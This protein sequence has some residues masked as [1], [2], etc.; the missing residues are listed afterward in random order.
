MVFVIAITFI[1]CDS[2]N[3]FDCI[4]AEGSTVRE[5]KILPDFQRILVNRGV[6]LI[7]KQG[8]TQQVIIEA[9]ENLIND[10][11]AEVIGDRLELTDENMCNFVRDYGTTKVYVTSPNITEIR[12]STQYDISSDGVLTYSRLRLLSEDFNSP[13]SFTV[14]DFRLHVATNELSVTANNISF[15]YINGTT[16]SLSVGF[17][18]GAGRFEGADLIA[19][20]VDIYHRGSNDITVNPV[21]SLVGELRGT[22]NLVALNEPPLVAVERFYTG[23]LFMN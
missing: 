6:E 4:Q 13:D 19:Q 21:Q 3:A 16:E 11:R 22:G 5:E 20:N 8:D 1:G 9:G 18:A 17:F 10:V 23:Q 7:L 2:E 12:S 14:G 15:F